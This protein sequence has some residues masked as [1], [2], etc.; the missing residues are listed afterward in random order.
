MKNI[1]EK[2]IPGSECEPWKDKEGAL[3]NHPSGL[4]TN[5][6]VFFPRDETIRHRR[7]GASTYVSL[8]DREIT[9]R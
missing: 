6:S 7:A 2:M 4:E 1:L 5:E 3:R 9:Q 8:C